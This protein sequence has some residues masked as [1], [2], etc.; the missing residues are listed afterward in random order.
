[1]EKWQAFTV[2]RRANQRNHSPYRG[3]LWTLAIESTFS[4]ALLSL[5]SPLS[6]TNPPKLSPSPSSSLHKQPEIQDSSLS[7]SRARVLTVFPQYRLLP[8]PSPS[9]PLLPRI[10]FATVKTSRPF[11]PPTLHPTP[12]NNTISHAPKTIYW[13]TAR[14]T[15]HSISCFAKCLRFFAIFFIFPSIPRLFASVLLSLCLSRRIK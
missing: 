12:L 7:L 10:T 15:W 6:L 9:T 3:V 13:N 5:P 11:S 1:M 2:A 14:G 8:P 4:K